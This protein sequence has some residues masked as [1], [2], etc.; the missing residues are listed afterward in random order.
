MER[1]GDIDRDRPRAALRQQRRQAQA[2][3]VVG[4]DGER[5]A[6]IVQTVDAADAAEVG[7][8]EGRKPAGALAQRELE[9]RH[10]GQFAAQT[11]HFDGVDAVRIEAAAFA[12]RV[13]KDNRHR[14]RD[15]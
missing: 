5:R 12:E 4:H 2:A 8:P 7:V 15:L 3:R 1:D 13:L 6:R 11:E 9:R 10:G 14:R